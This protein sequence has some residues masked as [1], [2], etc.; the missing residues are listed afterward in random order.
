MS[1]NGVILFDGCC[2]ICTRSVQFIIKRDPWV[3]FKFAPMQSDAGRKLL[4]THGLQPA[5][6]DTIILV[7][8]SG[9]F[10]KSDAVIGVASRLS[11]FWPIFRVLSMIPRPI[12]DWCYDAIAKNRYRWFGKRK[13]CMVPPEDH[14]NRFFQ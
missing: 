12:R 7:E 1:K 13:T 4:G 9:C 8:G 11:G 14:L 10:T 5:T 2:N 3:Y 6:T